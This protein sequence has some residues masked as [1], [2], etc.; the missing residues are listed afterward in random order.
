MY[1][2]PKNRYVHEG[3][4]LVGLFFKPEHQEISHGWISKD[5]GEFKLNTFG[6]KTFIQEGDLLLRMD[7]TTAFSIYFV[8]SKKEIVDNCLMPENFTGEENPDTFFRSLNTSTRLLSWDTVADH[9]RGVECRT[10][11][12]DFFILMGAKEYPGKRV[13]IDTLRQVMADKIE[14]K[15]SKILLQIGDSDVA[16]TVEPRAL[17]E[18]TVD[19]NSTHVSFPEGGEYNYLR[20]S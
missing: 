9:Y 14:L 20:L 6:T 17:V 15:R 12:P 2:A 18:G 7:L 13:S 5:E 19:L 1:V 10:K 8:L 3:H 4:T 16:F 11:F